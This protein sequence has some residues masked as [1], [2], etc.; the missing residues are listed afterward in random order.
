MC[1]VLRLTHGKKSIDAGDDRTPFDAKTLTQGAQKSAESFPPSKIYPDKA[2][3]ESAEGKFSPIG[4]N[5]PLTL[6]MFRLV[7]MLNVASKS[8]LRRTSPN[9]MPHQLLVLA[10]IRGTSDCRSSICTVEYRLIRA[11]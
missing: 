10:P 11:M 4:H 9:P 8:R 2:F 1:P 5:S 7:G 3:V 6:A